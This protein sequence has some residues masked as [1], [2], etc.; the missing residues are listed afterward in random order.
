MLEC[1]D[2]KLP[3]A[4]SNSRTLQLFFLNDNLLGF[5][6]SNPLHLDQ[7]SFQEADWPDFEIRDPT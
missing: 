3:Q 2:I 1:E 4:C 7:I 6:L 5:G